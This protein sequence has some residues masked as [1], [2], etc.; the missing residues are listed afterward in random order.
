VAEGGQQTFKVELT[1][2]MSDL[3]QNFTQVLR[4]Q[5]NK[6]DRCGEQIAIRN[7]ALTPLPPAG[8]VMVQLHYERWA[9]FGSAQNEMAEG[10]GT[11]EL[12]LTPTV[13]DDGTLRLLAEVRRIDAAGMVGE[14]LHSGSLGDAVRDAVMQSLLSTMRQGED[15]KATLPPSAQ[16]YATLRRAQFQGTGAGK[17]RAVL[18]GEIRV[19]N[20]K[21]TALTS[22]LKG[23]SAAPDGAQQT[24]PR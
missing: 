16:G 2:D 19:S 21:A 9:C 10:N 1:A 20:E 22:D 11:I 12:R 23:R 6:A 18:D 13:G 4:A 7:A 5:L 8:L 17:L 15:F 14:L 24:V 3:Q